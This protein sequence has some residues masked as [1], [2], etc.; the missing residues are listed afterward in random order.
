M[1]EGVISGEIIVNTI[2]V[3]RIIKSVWVLN[4][5]LSHIQKVQLSHPVYVIELLGKRS[6]TCYN[7]TRTTKLV[8]C[9]S[10][11]AECGYQV[12]GF[13]QISEEFPLHNRSVFCAW[14]R[15][16]NFQNP[17]QYSKFYENYLCYVTF[18]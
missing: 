12:C 9:D 10:C 13:I 3:V 11:C 1:Q 5:P 17:L 6:M 2:Y 16:Q 7:W 18:I 4:R 14:S 15:L 8:V